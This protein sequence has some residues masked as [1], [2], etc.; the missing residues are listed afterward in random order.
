[1]QRLKGLPRQQHRPQPL[2]FVLDVGADDG[3][4]GDAAPSDFSPPR[5]L[6]GI[7]SIYIEANSLIRG[8]SYKKVCFKRPKVLVIVM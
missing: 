8:L 2:D 3:D 6:P 7:Q 4:V 1:M 5:P